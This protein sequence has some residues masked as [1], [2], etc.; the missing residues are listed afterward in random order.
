MTDV[1]WAKNEGLDNA[2]PRTP[3]NSTRP[4]SASGASRS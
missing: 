2:V 3:E 4:A 1:A